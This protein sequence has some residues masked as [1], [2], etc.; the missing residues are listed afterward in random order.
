MDDF[1]VKEDC[2]RDIRAFGNVLKVTKP[3]GSRKR[4]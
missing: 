1:P 3:S 2:D 4:S